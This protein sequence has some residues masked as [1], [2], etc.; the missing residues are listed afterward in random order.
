MDPLNNEIY[1]IGVRHMLVKPE[2]IV[3]VFKVFYMSTIDRA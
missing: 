3:P 2:Y 1:K